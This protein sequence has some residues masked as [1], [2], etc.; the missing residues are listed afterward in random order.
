MSAT[1]STDRNLGKQFPTV[2]RDAGLHVLVHD[3]HF[4]QRTPDDVWLPEVGRAGWVVLTRDRQIRWKANE[5]DAVMENGIA[6]FALSGR[7]PT[8]E[9]ADLVIRTAPAVER[10]LA[11]H[12][13]PFL[14]KIQPA[15]P[16][17]RAGATTPVRAP[18]GAVTM[19][20]TE[21]QWRA[22]R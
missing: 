5:R 4:P 8:P 9:L 14:A 15:L 2:L 20:L 18:S 7:G 1:Y 21:A 17:K 13:R 6:L 16:A 19:W 11:R 22:E 3:D 12:A 10:F